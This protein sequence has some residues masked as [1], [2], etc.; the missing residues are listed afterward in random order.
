M[1]ADIMEKII[2]VVGSQDIQELYLDEY[3]W[4]DEV[5]AALG[6]TLC[7]NNTLKILSL[8]GE[9]YDHQQGRI[10][11]M[12]STGVE[13]VTDFLSTPSSSLKEL[14]FRNNRIGPLG[15]IALAEALEGNTTLKHLDLYSA[16]SPWYGE[17]TLRDGPP[18][19]NRCIIVHFTASTSVGIQ[20]RMAT[21]PPWSKH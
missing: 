3:D 10:G 5:A 4:D 12:D 1:T 13:A 14:S 18:S 16:V 19:L 6:D 15:G 17:H 8:G 21:L 11:S 9:K 7:T 2:N 20:L